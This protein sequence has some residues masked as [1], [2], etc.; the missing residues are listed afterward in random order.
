MIDHPL[1]QAVLTDP[2]DDATRLVLADWLE[3][4]GDVRGEFIRLQVSSAEAKL[5]GAQVDMEADRRA[6]EIYAQERRRW[7]ESLC[8]AVEGQSGLTLAETG[9]L[10]QRHLYH[11]GLPS[12]IRLTATELFE[13]GD[14]LMQA[15]PWQYFHVAWQEDELVELVDWDALAT[16]RTL[17]LLASDNYNPHAV[18]K[19]LDTPRLDALARLSVNAVGQASTGIWCD[20]ITHLRRQGRL[21]NLKECRVDVVRLIQ[22]EKNV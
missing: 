3:E 14:A 2:D 1:Y 4:Q 9:K 17:T 13:Y 6:R 20:S 21:A 22:D 18:T 15:S 8:R 10:T 5:Q 11:R 7:H 19:F 12:W 16:V